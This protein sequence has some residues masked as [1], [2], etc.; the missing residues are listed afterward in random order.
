MATTAGAL[1]LVQN[2]SNSVKLLSAA[3]TAGTAPYTY[4][5]YRSQTSGFS[6]GPSNII[7]GATTLAYTDTGL[8][9]AS[10]YYYKVVATDSSSPAVTG[11]S[12]QLSV[13]TQPASQAQNQFS[14]SPLLGMIDMT[15]GPTNVMA[16]QIDAS[17]GS[18]VYYP[19]QFVKVV[20]N[21]LGGLPRVIGCSADAD[22]AL[23]AITYNIKNQGFGFE[24]TAGSVCEIALAGSVMWLYSSAAIT[25]QARV[26]LD[27]SQPGSVQPTG[28][29]TP[30]IVGWAMD[31]AAAMGQLIRVV[32]LTPSFA[33]A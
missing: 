25:Q 20:A 15:V 2:G 7:S 11:D 23:G 10:Q 17:A 8:I 27:A 32:L 4:Q 1:S 22:G 28:G 6:P 16:V 26:C 5:W 33:A 29:S 9:P 14:Q 13:L 18:A 24:F 21:T 12:A 3:A 19:G 31:G 30:N